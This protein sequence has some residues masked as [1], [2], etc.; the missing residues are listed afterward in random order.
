LTDARVA[1]SD[2]QLRSFGLIV[3]ACF[4]VIGLL[5]VLLRGESPR[6][7]ALVIAVTLTV[8]GV[9]VPRVL[10][11]VHRAWMQLA[12]VLGWINTRIILL[13]VFFVVIAPTGAIL[14]LIGRDI[15][16]LKFSPTAESY[17]VA[18]AARPG[19]HMR[20]QY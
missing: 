12:E 6:M 3:G 15:L 7:W 18:R 2:R 11:P 16:Q 14:R 17:R 10:R 19:S 8:L 9:L 20:R 1:I 5:P 13:A 4:A